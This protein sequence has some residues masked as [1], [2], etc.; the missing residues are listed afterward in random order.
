MIPRIVSVLLIAWGMNA[1][2]GP[3]RGTCPDWKPA[4]RNIEAA[5]DRN[6][7]CSRIADHFASCGKVRAWLQ[8]VAPADGTTVTA[9]DVER[10]LTRARTPD[11]VE[12][13][14]SVR[15]KDCLGAT[16][17]WK[18]CRVFLGQAPLPPE[19]R[20]ANLDPA[21]PSERAAVTALLDFALPTLRDRR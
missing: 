5:C 15:A 20:V 11:L 16:Y 8:A 18:E 9:F 12:S 14:T 21:L 1:M 19:N 4:E 7:D 17:S 6:P 13:E 3:L 2:A 10:A